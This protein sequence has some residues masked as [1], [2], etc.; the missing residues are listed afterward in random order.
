[1]GSYG[2]IRRNPLLSQVLFDFVSFVVGISVV[3]SRNPLLS[4]VLFDLNVSVNLYLMIT[5]S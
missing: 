1:M 3:L 5:L 2:R 4:Q